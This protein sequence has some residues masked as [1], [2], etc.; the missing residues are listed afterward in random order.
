MLLGASW[1]LLGSF[2]ALL[3][4]SWAV[5]GRSEGV[6]GWSWAAWVCLILLLNRSVAATGCKLAL[7]NSKLKRRFPFSAA[8]VLGFRDPGDLMARP[9][10][11]TPTVRSNEHSR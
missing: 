7:A 2:G 1:A 6:L 4:R 5:L 9:Y 3:G 10:S 11:K 8:Q